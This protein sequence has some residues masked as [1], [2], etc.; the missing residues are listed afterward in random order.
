FLYGGAS[1]SLGLVLAGAS[2]DDRF[3]Q[4]V[5]VL[6]DVNCDGRADAFVGAPGDDTLAKDAGIVR[7]VSGKD[8]TTIAAAYGAAGE[9]LGWIASP[10]GDANGDGVPDGIAGA[11]AIQVISWLPPGLTPFG[12]GTPGCSGPQTLAGSDAPFVGNAAFSIACA[13]APPSSIGVGLLSG[14]A[15]VDGSDPLGLGIVLHVDLLSVA[16]TFDVESDAAGAGAAPLPIPGTASLAGKTAYA[17]VV[18]YWPMGEPCWPQGHGLT[19]SKGLAI[20]IS[21]IDPGAGG[22]GSPAKPP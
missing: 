20:E 7:V 14:G 6:G 3:G 4:A 9:Q 8:G 18:W 10:A 17:Q 11:G 1:L 22:P 19:T 2:V 12:A 13:L 21:A 15:D 5:S 16:A